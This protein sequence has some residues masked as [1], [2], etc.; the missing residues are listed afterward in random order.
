MSKEQIET[1]E[2]VTRAAHMQQAP[3]RAAATD[4]VLGRYASLV[5]PETPEEQLPSE[6]HQTL[7]DIQYHDINTEDGSEQIRSEE[8]RLYG[9]FIIDAVGL[10]PHV[11]ADFLS[12]FSVYGNTVFK[13]HR[14][15]THNPEKA[16]NIFSSVVWIGRKADYYGKTDTDSPDV[17]RTPFYVVGEDDG[18]LMLVPATVD[19]PQ[20][21]NLK[22]YPLDSL[23]R[24]Y[25]NRARAL[26]F[27]KR[28]RFTGIRS[29]PAMHPLDSV[30]KP[31]EVIPEKVVKARDDTTGLYVI[32]ADTEGINLETFDDPYGYG[33]HSYD[34]TVDAVELASFK[35]FDCLRSLAQRFHVEERYADLVHE[36]DERMP[37]Y[38][39]GTEPDEA[40][41][42]LL[43]SRLATKTRRR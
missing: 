34:L 21:D 7:G 11:E 41:L 6:A 9:K 1:A 33:V 10:L 20:E 32:G 27:M 40:A 19:V 36:L 5:G 23:V 4:A 29:F 26:H 14:F 37:D 18:T 39:P 17:I 13:G 12:E 2:I 43:G 38:Q 30:G 25:N 16:Q 31:K 22:S 28:G 8:E 15:I 42:A 3:Y 24:G 35:V